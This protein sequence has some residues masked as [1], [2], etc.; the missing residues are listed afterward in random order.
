MRDNSI[1]INRGS[2]KV[3]FWTP[4]NEHKQ[5]FDE[6]Y[7]PACLGDGLRDVVKR[8]DLIVVKDDPPPLLL[9]QLL[10]VLRLRM[11]CGRQNKG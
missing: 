11:P 10:L 4:R 1:A 9:C 7:N 8:V 3:S 5:S 2:P 6:A